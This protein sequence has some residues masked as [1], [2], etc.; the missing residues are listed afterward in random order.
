[1]RARWHP[2]PAVLCASTYQMAAEFLVYRNDSQLFGRQTS[3]A[4]ARAHIGEIL[5]AVSPAHVDSWRALCRTGARGA[6]EESCLLA[7]Q[8]IC[9]HGEG[10]GFRIPNVGERAEAFDIRPYVE[11]LMRLRLSARDA[12]NAIGNAFDHR[13]LWAAYGPGVVAHLQGLP[14][15][16]HCFPHPRTIFLQFEKALACCRAAR[17]NPHVLIPVPFALRGIVAWAT[18]LDAELRRKRGQAPHLIDLDAGAGAVPPPGYDALIPPQFT[19]TAGEAGCGRPE[20]EFRNLCVIDAILQSIGLPPA[21]S[22]LEQALL[23]SAVGIEVR[24]LCH[25]PEGETIPTAAAWL[26]IATVRYGV[27][28]PRPHLVEFLVGC[29]EAGTLPYRGSHIGMHGSRG[30]WNGRCVAIA[31]NGSH[32]VPVYWHPAPDQESSAQAAL[33]SVPFPRRVGPP[34]VDIAPELSLPALTALAHGYMVEESVAIPA[35]ANRAGAEA[36]VR[37]IARGQDITLARAASPDLPIVRALP[38]A[39]RVNPAVES[40]THGLCILPHDPADRIGREQTGEFPQAQALGLAPA[41]QDGA[42]GILIVVGPDEWERP[43]LVATPRR[44]PMWKALRCGTPSP[45]SAAEHGRR[46]R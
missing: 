14:R 9:E 5:A 42:P 22:C 37:S 30:C 34:D 31:S 3:I 43:V 7:A 33:L 29:N 10:H 32:S 40:P 36:F 27:V 6:H 12:F 18:G 20:P 35:P 4:M 23:V 8:W 13:M 38:A 26:F 24:A 17:Y 11:E 39:R 46:S 41:H 1:M 2:N 15:R 25:I 28:D 44:D 19:L 45:F 16:R 21:R